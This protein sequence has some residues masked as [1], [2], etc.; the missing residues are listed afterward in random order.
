M[1]TTILSILICGVPSRLRNN[2]AEKLITKLEKQANGKP[3]EVLYFLDNKKRSIGQKRNDLLNLAKGEYITYIDDDDNVPMD[4]ISSLLLGIKTRVD[5]IVFEAEIS[6][7]G[8]TY[9]KV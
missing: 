3:V 2:L 6:I 8:S 5:V 7:N 9:K 1:S 4:Y